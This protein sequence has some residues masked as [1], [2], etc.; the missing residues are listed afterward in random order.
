MSRRAV[1]A[2]MAAAMGTTVTAV[3]TVA[4]PHAAAEEFV[5]LLNVTVR[6]G[7]NFASPDAA[8]TYGRG[9]CAKLAEGTAYGQLVDD[10]RRDFGTADEFQA[11]Y[12]VS[13]AVNELCPEMI[14]QL[15]SSASGYRSGE[16]R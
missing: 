1:Y 11:S 16:V 4:A 14:W 5:Y 7:Y 3:A 10:V 15:R 12:L 2:V 8:L 9:V 6:P 13:Q